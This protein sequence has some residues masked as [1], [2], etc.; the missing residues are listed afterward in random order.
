MRESTGKVH[1]RRKEKKIWREGG[2][3]KRMGDSA[4]R[5]RKE[6]WT[7][8]RT[9]LTN[10][11]FPSPLRR[12]EKA[13]GPTWTTRVSPSVTAWLND[14]MWAFVRSWTAPCCRSFSFPKLPSV[15]FFR[16]GPWGRFVHLAEGSMA[17]NRSLFTTWSRWHRKRVS[18]P[19]EEK[20]GTVPSSD[21]LWWTGGTVTALWERGDFCLEN[22][23]LR[24]FCF[25]FLV[26]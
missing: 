10:T 17:G 12:R 7:I 1:I 21:T 16:L 26:F 23:K 25:F 19:Q 5:G 13:G 22:I 20:R 15:R 14:S 2:I 18:E 8:L 11:S 3:K 24:V 4:D 6:G 9:V